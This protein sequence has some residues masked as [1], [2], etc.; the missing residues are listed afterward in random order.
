MWRNHWPQAPIIKYYYCS[1]ILINIEINSPND[2]AF[3]IFIGFSA[4]KYKIYFAIFFRRC[5]SLISLLLGVYAAYSDGWFRFISPLT[6]ISC[7]VFYA[8][9][10][11]FQVKCA[12][13]NMLPAKN[14]QFYCWFICKKINF[15]LCFFVVAIEIGGKVLRYHWK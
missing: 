5:G 2:V 13:W 6:G 8:I 15:S 1:G 9:F 14:I 7:C 3:T 12:L 11:S 4:I 10:F